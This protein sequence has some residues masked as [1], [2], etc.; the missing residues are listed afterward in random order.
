MSTTVL[1]FCLAIPERCFG[2]YRNSHLVKFS[3]EVPRFP[4]AIEAWQDIDTAL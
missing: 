2:I 3:V 4:E 1:L